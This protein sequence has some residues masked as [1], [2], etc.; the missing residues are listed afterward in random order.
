MNLVLVL[1]IIAW[2]CLG[3]LVLVNDSKSEITQVQE[4]NA[5]YMEEERRRHRSGRHSE[6]RSLWKRVDRLSSENR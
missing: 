1:W 2:V 6:S 4:K 3:I 5:S